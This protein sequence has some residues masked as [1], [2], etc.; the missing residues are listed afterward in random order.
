MSTWAGQP[1]V[2]GSS[3][4]VRMVLLTCVSIGITFTWGVEMTYCTPYLLSLGLSKSQT[5]L[6]WV[7]GPLSGLIVQPIIGVIADESTSKWGRRRPIIAIGSVI[8]A[9]SLLALGFTKEIV[10]S[11]VSDPYTVKVLTIMTAVLSLYCVDF[12]INAVMSCARSLV[13]DTLPIHKQQTGAAWGSRMNS[14]GHIIG[15]AMG[16]LDLV[17]IF[18][19]RLGDSQFKQLT[20]VAALGMLLT[21]AITCWAVTER[22]LI[23]VRHDPRRAQGRFKVVRQIY[24]TLLTLP[25]RIRG[26]CNAVFWSWIGWF[27]FIIYSSTWVGE[28]YFRY[29]VAANARDSKDALGDMGR[30]GS[31][32]LT[33]YS[34]VAFISAW[35]L[36]ALIQAPE[37]DTFTHRPPA[38]LAPFI[39][40]FNKVKPDL[41]T[42]WI[43]SSVVFSLTMFFTPFATSFRLATVIVAFCGIPWCV[44]QWAPVTFLGVEVNKLSGSAEPSAAGVNGRTIPPA[45]YRR[46][47]NDSSGIEMLSLEHGPA[48]LE[49]GRPAANGSDHAPTSSTGELSGIY[50]G[51]LNIYITIPQF[52]STVMSGAVFSL[53][54]P[55]KSPELA[56][57]AHPS[58]TS[59]PS[60]PNA[61]AV[62]MFLGAISSLMAAWTTRKLRD[63]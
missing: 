2:E 35:I 40:T 5:S 33:V 59:D 25:P 20:V 56:T 45:S 13:V 36:P 57:E 8:V 15:Y 11:F 61:I 38:S 23:S 18:G 12:S 32:A 17:Q 1:R 30:I 19:P 3:E 4:T 62:C 55:G 47:S 27:P 28:T 34:T 50:F 41:L 37:D 26:I 7:A 49:A 42:A 6:V 14:L 46:L 39:E 29:D 16:A 10:T 9:L 52:L 58:E 48:S 53:L 31:M 21:S 43:V 60:G 44:S 63:L 24:S 22:V 51:I 54:E